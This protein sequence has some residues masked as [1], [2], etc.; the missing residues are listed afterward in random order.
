[1]KRIILINMVLALFVFTACG[2]NKSGGLVRN[3]PAEES[4]SKVPTDKI[5]DGK[6]APSTVKKTEKEL[7]KLRGTRNGDSPVKAEKDISSSYKDSPIG[8]EKISAR[9]APAVSGLKAGYAD[10]NK[11]FN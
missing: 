8:V 7:S 11:Q 6:P 9:K 10:D 2:L 1:M 4:E 3:E 5:S